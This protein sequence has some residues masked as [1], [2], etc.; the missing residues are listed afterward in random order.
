LRR[1]VPPEKLYFFNV[2]DGWEPLCKIL[3]VPVP[4]EPFPRANELEAMK[5]LEKVVIKIAWQ[6][7]AVILGAILIS[8]QKELYENHI[9]LPY[10]RK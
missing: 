9:S 1:I 5:E 8:M 10:V 3:D 2:K 4:D 7:W 6:R